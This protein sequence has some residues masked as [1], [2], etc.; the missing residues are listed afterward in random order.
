MSDLINIK[1]GIAILDPETAQRIADFERK[2][3]E[4]K[5]SEEE[6]KQGILEEMKTNHLLKI[7][8]DDLVIN[9]IAPTDRETFD[10]KAFRARYPDLY[11]QHIKL[12]PVKASVRIKLKEG[13]A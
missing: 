5:R 8:T 10:T 12:S 11:D 2:I 13:E 7:E 3:K 4:I 6:L 9:Y 1:E